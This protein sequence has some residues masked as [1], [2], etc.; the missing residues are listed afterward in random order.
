MAHHRSEPCG[1]GDLRTLFLFDGLTDEQLRQHCTNARI[2][3]EP[4]NRL[5]RGGFR[6]IEF[7]LDLAMS[8]RC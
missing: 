7:I 8:V 3:R 5:S 4:Q 2:G 1:A 6:E